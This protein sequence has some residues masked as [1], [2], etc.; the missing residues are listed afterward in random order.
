MF[1]GS[2]LT[3]TRFFNTDEILHTVFQ[4][5]DT[6]LA[7]QRNIKVGQSVLLRGARVWDDWITSAIAFYVPSILIYGWK[8]RK[9]FNACLGLLSRCQEEGNMVLIA[10]GTPHMNFPNRNPDAYAVKKE[11][12]VSYRFMKEMKTNCLVR[13]K[14]NDGEW[15]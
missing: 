2:L 4:C 8:Q 9:S 14:S 15:S 13:M 7:V 12:A 11:W 10:P 1:L 5:F 6:F 3:T